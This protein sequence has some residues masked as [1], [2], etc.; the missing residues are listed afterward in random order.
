MKGENPTR[1]S[2]A[3]L[4]ARIE[5][6]RDRPQAEA[7]LCARF[8]Q[9]VYLYG[10]RHLHS[11]SDAED[12][13]HDVLAKVIERVRAGG[14][15]EPEKLG[16]FVLGVCRTL[17]HERWRIESRRTKIL[18]KYGDTRAAAADASTSEPEASTALLPRVRSCLERLGDRDRTVLLL[19]F[20]AELDAT[21]LAR[22]LAIEATHVRVIR[23]RAL[24]RLRACVE[25]LE[26]LAK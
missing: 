25:A 19:S 16:S 10:V 18:A 15:N 2:D 24:G 9:R 23:H 8:R 4:V 13:T 17:L 14:M 12:L 11:A 3:I 21:A 20:Y 6:D 5:Q 7:E 22:E 26:E 1:P